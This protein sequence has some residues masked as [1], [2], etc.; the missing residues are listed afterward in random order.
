[1]NPLANSERI[2]ES[3][4]WKVTQWAIGRPLGAADARE[5]SSIHKRARE[6]GGTYQSLMTAI[7]M[8]DLIQMTGSH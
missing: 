2:S 7:V 4:T 3:L 8:S 6:N 5:I 1:M